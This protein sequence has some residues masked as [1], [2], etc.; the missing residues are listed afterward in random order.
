MLNFLLEVG[1]E[2]SVYRGGISISFRI[3][4]W[5]IA[6]CENVLFA[7]KNTGQVCLPRTNDLS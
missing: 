5:G 3:F 6:S 2:V 1:H 4:W 7:E